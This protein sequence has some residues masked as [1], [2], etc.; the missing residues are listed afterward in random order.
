MYL[1]KGAKT[2]RV[3]HRLMTHPH[4][5]YVISKPEKKKQGES[6]IDL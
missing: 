3:R 4:L 2:K 1:E 5:L 6:A